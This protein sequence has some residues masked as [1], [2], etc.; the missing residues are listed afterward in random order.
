MENR[1]LLIEGAA[2]ILLLSSLTNIALLAGEPNYYYPD[3]HFRLIEYTVQQIKKKKAAGGALYL[4]R[5]SN[6]ERSIIAKLNGSYEIEKNI[7]VGNEVVIDWSHRKEDL[8]KWDE[9]VG[10]YPPQL[11]L[12]NFTQFFETEVGCENSI[13][14]KY[15]TK[16]EW[17]SGIVKFNLG[18][19]TAFN[20]TIPDKVFDSGLNYFVIG[21]NTRY[22]SYQI[23]TPPVKIT[24]PIVPKFDLILHKPPTLLFEIKQKAGEKKIRNYGWVG[25]TFILKP[26]NYLPK[27]VKQIQI[28][29]EI[30][31]PPNYV[32]FSESEGYIKYIKEIIFRKLNESK[33]GKIKE[34]ITRKNS[35]N[36]FFVIEDTF[37]T[38]T[39]YPY[40]YIYIRPRASM[41]I[42]NYLE[43]AQFD[44]NTIYFQNSPFTFCDVN[45][46]D[47]TIPFTFRVKKIV[48]T[49]EDNTIAESTEADVISLASQHPNY[50]IIFEKLKTLVDKVYKNQ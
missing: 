41:D 13:P 14:I 42:E 1:K 26:R 50:L 43:I 44:D 31:V 9:L 20:C 47:C 36:V 8:P 10:T 17:E 23:V 18:R 4:Y 12:W 25:S 45:K 2:F 28:E 34:L 27:R 48:L 35:T 29:G 7:Q 49:Y 38:P 16:E 22:F 6:L 39:Y 30:S 5:I 19:I 32:S 15:L 21:I 40:G 37:T 46:N 24:K 3:Y 33:E 11:Q